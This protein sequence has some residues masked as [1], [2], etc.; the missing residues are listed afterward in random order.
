MKKVFIIGASS[1][2]GY[3]TAQKFVK[4]GDTVINMSRTPC[5]IAGVENILCDVAGEEYENKL[6]V[7]KSRLDRLDI[8]IYSAG[9][10]MAAPLEH[11]H[12]NDYRY[13]FEVNFFGFVKALQILLPTLRASGG[14][15]C[16]ISSIGGILPIAYDCYY[17]SSK[18]ALNMLINAL[19]LELTPK[20][21]KVISIMPGGTKTNFSFKRKVYSKNQVGDYATAQNSALKNLTNIEQSG[22][23]AIS[24][25]NTI[26]RQCTKPKAAHTVASGT[27]NK[28]FTLSSKIFPQRLLYYLNT[29]IY[30]K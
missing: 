23:S 26:Y 22:E 2:I 6:K 4:N 3:A 12:E 19:S 25:A 27:I 20:G 28:L 10:S 16:V 18:A 9:F 24:V 1:G 13:L 21:V 30:F 8:F 15:A 5:E 14:V 11:V 29:K 7:L 17:S